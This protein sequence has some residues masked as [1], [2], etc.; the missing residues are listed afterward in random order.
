MSHAD[1]MR[2]KRLE[3]EVADLRARVEVIE[4]RAET[5]IMVPPPKPDRLSLRKSAPADG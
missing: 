3:N 2:M 4:A 1:A 5:A